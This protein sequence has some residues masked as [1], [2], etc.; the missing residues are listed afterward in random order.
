M[1]DMAWSTYSTQTRGQQ[2]A[3]QLIQILDTNLNR[4]SLIILMWS[5]NLQ[6]DPPK[7]LGKTKQ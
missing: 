1:I 3:E 2:N 5:E 4:N 7:S 6:I